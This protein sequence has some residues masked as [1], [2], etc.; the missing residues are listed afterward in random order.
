MGVNLL[1]KQTHRC[2]RN[3]T[4]QGHRVNCFPRIYSIILLKVFFF[5]YYKPLQKDPGLRRS[6]TMTM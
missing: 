2:L 4:V 6:F 1:E 3:H 5:C